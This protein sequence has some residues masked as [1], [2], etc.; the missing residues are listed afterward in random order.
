MWMTKESEN[1]Q[2]ILKRIYA[3]L[4]KKT[5]LKYSQEL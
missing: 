5:L 3:Y 1:K 4:D 2:Q